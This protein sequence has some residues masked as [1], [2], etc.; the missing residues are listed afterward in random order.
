M[1]VL[2]VEDNDDLV[3]LMTKAMSRVGLDID[4][5]QN[6]ADAEASL[7]TVQYAAVV[8]DLGLP[9]ADG[10]TPVSYTHLTLPTKRIV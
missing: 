3:A 9:D 2:V 4:S 1:R 7:R 6:V 5:A 8:L 10:L